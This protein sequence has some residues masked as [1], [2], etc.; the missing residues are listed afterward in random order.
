MEKKENFEAHLIGNGLSS[1][2]KEAYTLSKKS[3]F[4]EKKGE[5][6]FY[7]LVEGFF[8]FK[9]KGLK[10]YS[11]K[12]VL[13]EKEILTK[14]LRMDKNFQLK[15][16]VF[17]DLRKKGFILKSGIKFGADF[18]V[19]EKGEKPGKTHSKWLLSIEQHSKKIKWEEFILKNRVANS[20][21]KKRLLAIQD[22]EGNIIYSE[23]S[24]KK[25]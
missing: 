19:Y 4:G 13:N 14:F 23:I 17:E 2:S 6:I 1:N 22:L 7:S 5:K 12:K 20:T 18:S 24:W 21:K 15:Y 9:I 11:G 8:L 3:F 25:I 10:I 16:K